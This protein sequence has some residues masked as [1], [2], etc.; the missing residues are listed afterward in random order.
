[1]FIFV[2]ALMIGNTA[3]DGEEPLPGC[4][5]TYYICTISN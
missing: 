2:E 1:M 5:L 3:Q 4:P